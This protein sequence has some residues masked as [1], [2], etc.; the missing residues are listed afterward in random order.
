MTPPLIS[1]C[2]PTYNGAATLT[3]TLNSIAAQEF[4]GLEVVIC[5]D[6]SSDSTVELAE[7]FARR[8]LYVRGQ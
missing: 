6:Q 2:V 7:A 5:D 8:H 3:Q 1:I 4:D